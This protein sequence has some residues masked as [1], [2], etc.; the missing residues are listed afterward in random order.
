MADGADDQT[1]GFGYVGDAFGFVGIIWQQRFAGFVSNVFHAKHQFSAPDL[2][3]HG[4][5]FKLC[6]AEFEIG[7]DGGGVLQKV[8]T[9]NDFD[10]FERSNAGDRV[11]GIGK[12]GGEPTGAVLRHGIPDFV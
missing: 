9:F 10:V 4:Q 6:H 1:H 11:T 5:G 12:A 8:F 7:A 3:D 2:A